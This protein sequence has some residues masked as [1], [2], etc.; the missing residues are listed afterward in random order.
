MEW[1]IEKILSRVSLK[2]LAKSAYAVIR[3]KLQKMVDATDT[4]FDNE[5]LEVVDA[6]VDALIGEIKEA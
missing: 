2:K 1:I 6:V 4:T 5:A 3:K